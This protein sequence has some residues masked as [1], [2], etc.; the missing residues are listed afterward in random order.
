MRVPRWT[1]LHWAVLHHHLETVKLLLELDADDTIGHEW[2]RSPLDIARQTG[3]KEMISVLQHFSH[4]GLNRDLQTLVP[5]SSPCLTIYQVRPADQDCKFNTKEVSS[6]VLRSTFSQYIIFSNPYTAPPRVVVGLYQ[7]NMSASRN[8]R[9]KT[10][11]NE[12]LP[13]RFLIHIDSWAGSI[14]YSAGSTWFVVAGN[15]LDYQFGSFNTLEDHSWDEPQAITKRRIEFVR[16]YDCPPEVVVW[17]DCL[18][19]DRNWDWRV[20]ATANEIDSTGFTLQIEAL[21]NC[22]LFGGRVVDRISSMERWSC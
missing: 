21:G 5:S 15:D 7:I 9:I 2:N 8:I 6:E 17:L 11:A 22:A 19:I 20:R 16:P 13:D 12:V 14:L 4:K 18:D 3:S 10:Y 1:A